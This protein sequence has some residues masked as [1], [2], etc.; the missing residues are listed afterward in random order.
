MVGI[1]SNY[2]YYQSQVP[3]T[4]GSNTSY[5]NTSFSTN[6]NPYQSDNF[7]IENTSKAFDE[8]M[9]RLTGKSVFNANTTTQNAALPPGITQEELNWA[10]ELENKV[11]NGYTPNAQETAAYQSLAAKMSNSQTNNINQSNATKTQTTI[12]PTQEEINWALELENRV[13]SG[14]TPNAQETAKYQDIAN[15][16]QSSQNTNRTT[17]SAP[18]QEEIN[19]A[20]EL[21]NRV[22]GGYTPNAQETAKYQDIA[23]RLQSSQN[24]N[25][26]SN[27]DWVAWSQPFSVPRSVFQTTP[28]II[29]VP[30]TLR[31]MNNNIPTTVSVNVGPN[32]NNNTNVF[33]DEIQWALNLENRVKS[34]Y[35]PTES[36]LYQYKQIADKLQAM[37]NNS[38]N[39]QNSNNNIQNNNKP[40]SFGERIKNA[41]NA[42]IGK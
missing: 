24:T 35:N 1:N 7:S 13:K 26:S 8:A 36:E 17:T 20:L 21:E 40:K 6:Y 38:N 16:L 22:K 30:A 33:N 39:I 5:G 19:W 25:N 34:G 9:A 4:F 31:K 32:L 11:R 3:S 37:K 18:T 42:L 41:W 14:Y 10:L 29:Q 27:K 28:R 2:G 15:R 12:T 23:N